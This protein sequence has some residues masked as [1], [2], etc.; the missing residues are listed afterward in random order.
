MR[1]APILLGLF[2][3]GGVLWFHNGQAFTSSLVA[4]FVLIAPIVRAALYS[5]DPRTP[6]KKR[7]WRLL[8]ISMALLALGLVA[9]LPSA[10]RSQREFNDAAHGAQ[11]A[12]EKAEGA[13]NK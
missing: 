13:A 9:R 10:Y 3:A 4:L 6:S 8:A 5:I 2:F 11:V 1:L 12:S 7:A